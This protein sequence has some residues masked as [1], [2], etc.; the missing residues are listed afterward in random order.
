VAGV[1]PAIESVWA[2]C[3]KNGI[4]GRTVTL[5]IRYADFQLITRSR[6]APA[7]IASREVLERVSLAL[8]A[9]LFPLAKS[10][11]L[12]GISMSSFDP[13]REVPREQLVLAL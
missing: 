13:P 2:Y 3:E 1:Q 5:K 11:R 7:P 10:I 4:A 6:T 8:V 9:S 12:A